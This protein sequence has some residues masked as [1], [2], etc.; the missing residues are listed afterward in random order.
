MVRAATTAGPYGPTFADRL[1]R[2]SSKVQMTWRQV[3]KVDQPPP[4][5]T[6][7]GAPPKPP[8][9]ETRDAAETGLQWRRLVDRTAEMLAQLPPGDSS[10]N[11]SA[12]KLQRMHALM[13]RIQQM[14]DEVLSH[15]LSATRG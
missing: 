12:V 15:T 5:P 2:L 6:T 13:A 3:L 11:S 9:M 1:R 14:E 8:A 4:G 7:F 10:T